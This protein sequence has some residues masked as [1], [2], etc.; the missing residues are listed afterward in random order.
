[1]T[2]NNIPISEGD[3]ELVYGN[4]W[5]HPNKDYDF[6]FVIDEAKGTGSMKHPKNITSKELDDIYWLDGDKLKAAF[7]KAIK[8]YPVKPDI[9]N[10]SLGVKHSVLTEGDVNAGNKELTLNIQRQYIV[11]GCVDCPFVNHIH[12]TCNL[13][14]G[15]PIDVWYRSEDQEKYPKDC[16]LKSKTVLVKMSDGK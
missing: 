7:D 1:M 2:E 9:L 3:Q 8:E 16:P 6:V 15:R 11:N 4:F 14:N 10:Y 12:A 13:Q 5:N